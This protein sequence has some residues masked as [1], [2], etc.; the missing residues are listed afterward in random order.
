MAVNGM[1]HQRLAFCLRS[2]TRAG[3][4]D[5]FKSRRVA[6]DGGEGQPTPA[7]HLFRGLGSLST[8]RANT[9]HDPSLRL[10][11]AFPAQRAVAVAYQLVME[12]SSRPVSAFSSKEVTVHGR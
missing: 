9:D 6:S 11:M 7:R 5:A 10:R 2:G 12:A 3:C 1:R 4:A 8:W